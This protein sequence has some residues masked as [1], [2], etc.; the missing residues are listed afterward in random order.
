MPRGVDLNHFLNTPPPP[1]TETHVVV[2]YGNDDNEA[3]EFIGSVGGKKTYKEYLWTDPDCPGVQLHIVSLPAF[4]Q[5]H[6]IAR[7][8][9]DLARKL[10]DYEN[11]LRGL[12]YVRSWGADH[13]GARGTVNLDL[14][15]RL[16]GL[17][18]HTKVHVWLATNRDGHHQEDDLL[19]RWRDIVQNYPPDATNLKPSQVLKRAEKK[20]EQEPIAMA[21]FKEMKQHSLAK[22]KVGKKVIELIKEQISRGPGEAIV[23][24]L[25]EEMKKL[26]KAS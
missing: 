15:K 24:T 13:W 10:R 16:L 17:Q 21:I 20:K 26:K 1:R 7:N 25:K 22:T 23:K 3:A 11:Q 6:R 5:D 18:D 8:L 2:L 12:V 4:Q 14:L 9:I 19:E